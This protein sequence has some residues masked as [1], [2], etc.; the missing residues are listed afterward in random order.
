ME[1]P[2]GN[3]GDMNPTGHAAIYLNRVCAET[4]TQLRRCEAESRELSS[5]VIRVGAMTG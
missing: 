1:E 5:A 2:F 3:F 4:P